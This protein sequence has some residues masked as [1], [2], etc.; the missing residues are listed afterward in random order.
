M[1]TKLQSGLE[2]AI[3]IMFGFLIAMVAQIIVF[4]LFDIHIS[5]VDNFYIGLI[6]TVISFLRSYFIRRFFN[7]VHG[8]K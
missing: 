1:Q 3:N 6:F 4:P 5:F 7:T 2:A 8:E